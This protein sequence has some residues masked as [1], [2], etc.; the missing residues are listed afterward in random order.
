MIK[1]KVKYFLNYNKFLILTFVLIFCSLMLPFLGDTKWY[2]ISFIQYTEKLG[3]YAVNFIDLIAMCYSFILGLSLYLWQT[4]NSER[5]SKIEKLHLDFET[6]KFNVKTLM[7]LFLNK[8][9]N[10]SD[11][12]GIFDKAFPLLTTI[13]LVIYKLSS[14]S[15]LLVYY[16]YNVYEL[17]VKFEIYQ[18]KL[19]DLI[20][21]I[22][23]KDSN[24]DDFN[25]CVNE[26][27]V[28]LS[29]IDDLYL[30]RKRP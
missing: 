10:I 5:K 26:L 11:R 17:S 19:G 1:F 14:E 30:E 16:K 24:I 20:N 7:F 13:N 28:A 23:E 4:A 18:N 12:V 27:I 3:L 9:E 15:D 29:E 22:V 21:F 2:K 25:L 6:M 8:N